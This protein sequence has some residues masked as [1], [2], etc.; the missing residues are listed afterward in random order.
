MKAL[1]MA[2]S[3]MIATA[4]FASA[5]QCDQS[6]VTKVCS[7][8]IQDPYAPSY[9]VSVTLISSQGKELFAKV[10]AEKMTKQ[11]AINLMGSQS[12]R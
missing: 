9:Y 12:C 11:E 7:V 3:L 10:I 4:S 2:L 1:L 5:D 8:T 6:T